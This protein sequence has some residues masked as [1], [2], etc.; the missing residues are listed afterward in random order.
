MVQPHPAATG[1]RASLRVRVILLVF[2]AVLPAFGLIGWTAY[3]DRATRLHEAET[4]ARQI[5]GRAAAEFGQVV[6]ISHELMVRVSSEPSM[7]RGGD[8]VAC[9]RALA[10]VQ[11]R[12]A[13]YVNM[14][15][16]NLE[17]YTTC[18]D[19]DRALGLYVGD[20]DYF[21]RA[22]QTR[23]FVVSRF[24]VDRLG[25]KHIMVLAM[26]IIGPARELRDVMVL[27]LDLA[28]LGRQTEDSALPAGS[29]LFLVDDTG[30]VMTTYPDMPSAI[31]KRIP[32]SE[33]PAHEQQAGHVVTG[34][35]GQLRMVVS[36]PLPRAPAGS[37]WVRGS[38]PTADIVAGANRALLRNLAVLSGVALLIFGAAWW[39]AGLLVVRPTVRLIAMAEALG[40]GD[41]AARTRLDHGGGEL[42]QLARHFDDMAAS[43]QRMTRAQRALSASNRIVLRAGREQ[44]LLEEMCQIAVREGGYRVAWVGLLQPDGHLRTAAVAGGRGNLNQWVDAHAGKGQ[45]GPASVA[46]RT[47]TTQVVRNVGYPPPAG[48]P[49]D[50]WPAVFAACALPLM[51]RGRAIGVLKLYAD[52]AAAFDTAELELLEEMA[53]D[54]AFGILTLRDREQHQRTEEKIRLLALLDPLTGLP[55]RARFELLTGEA[56]DMVGVRR[57]HL[58]VLAV[59]LE[60]FS[61]IQNAVGFAESERLLTQVAAR[62]REVADAA[63][64]VA[65]LDGDRF[66][67]LVPWADAERALDI[68]RSLVGG[69]ERPFG[70]AGVDVEVNAN[71]GVALFP[72]HGDEPGML[73]RRADIACVDAQTNG[74]GV[75]L[76]RGASDTESLARLQLMV[77]LRRAIDEGQLA[78]HYQ[79]KIDARSGEV[80]GAEALLRWRHP[81]RGNIPPVQFIPAAEETGLIKLLTRWVINEVLRQQR[82]WADEGRSVPVAVNLSGRNFRDPGLLDELQQA[83]KRWQVDPRLLQIEITETVLMDDAESAQR[84]L[85]RMRAL[86]LVILIDDFGTGYSSLRYLASLPVDVIKIDRSFV[87]T[88]VHRQEM[89]ALVAAMIDMGHK[90]GMKLVAEGVDDESQAQLLREMGCDEIQ[91][92]LYCRPVEASAFQEWLGARVPQGRLSAERR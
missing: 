19:N 22:V 30:T 72:E 88:I 6:E 45:D 66:A 77:D 83:L 29:N 52:D 21:R 38:I 41:M 48:A 55:N 86:G 24:L 44:S 43:L 37:A 25:G 59:R 20:R 26:P 74:T 31:G 12:H 35:D 36:V 63:W 75:A 90:L 62:L 80:T 15:I 4:Q 84:V 2:L 7:R 54:L 32:E 81:V 65:R 73:A 40:R 17:G 56:L 92:F 69:F 33:K 9:G 39:F 87:I 8:R 50:D 28:W 51:L 53:A 27:S 85:E 13:A 18:S 70:V 89:R 71:V 11:Q 68:A 5:A 47:R 46:V 64:A 67:V 23:G 49:Q 57:A 82:E 16:V 10:E 34:F 79:G 1:W 3:V 58:A 60:R 78:V 76:F 91:G 14:A 42:G 61:R